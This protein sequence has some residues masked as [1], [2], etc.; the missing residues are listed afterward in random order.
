MITVYGI[1]GLDGITSAAPA[2]IL[3]RGIGW[4]VSRVW[5]P[6]QQ[7]RIFSFGACSDERH[8][9]LGQQSSEV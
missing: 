6:Y 3:L 4:S 2:N 9:L 1:I 7:E 8:C 5:C